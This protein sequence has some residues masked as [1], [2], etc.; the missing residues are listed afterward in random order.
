M[1]RQCWQ[2]MV[3][4]GHGSGNCHRTACV[5]YGS[6]SNATATAGGGRKVKKGQ[7]WVILWDDIKHNP[8]EQLKISR[9]A[10]IPRKS[11]LFR[12]ILNLS[13]AIKLENGGVIPSVNNTSEK[14]APK[15]AIDQLGHSLMRLIY[16]FAQ[17]DEDATIF[18]GNVGH[19]RW[20][21]ALGLCAG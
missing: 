11:R 18:Y 20:I 16:A 9:I 21:L 12:A 8:P 2:A 17:A 1:P 3:H 6:G 19:K 10:M 15:G 5:S 4:G 7:C 14:T 13:F